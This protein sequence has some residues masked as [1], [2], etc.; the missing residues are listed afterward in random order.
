MIDQNVLT[1]VD[2]PKLEEYLGEV[3]GRTYWEPS[4]FTAMGFP[5]DFVSSI[6]R[7]Y[8]SEG[9]DFKNKIIDQAK[10][11]EATEQGLEPLVELL[12]PNS[13]AYTIPQL[14][15]VHDL[16]F[17][18][19]LARA[20]GVDIEKIRYANEAHGRGTRARRFREA[21]I[22]FLERQSTATAE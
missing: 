18:P 7:N 1:D 21:I 9:G 12:D 16:D 19:K 6:T 20:L 11:R 8:E 10:V 3:C 22:E 13:T 5:S 17:L 4:Y 15:A 14:V 2:M